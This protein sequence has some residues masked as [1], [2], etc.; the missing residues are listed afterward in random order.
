MVV[1]CTRDSGWHFAPRVS[2]APIHPQKESEHDEALSVP[3]GREGGRASFLLPGFLA[4]ALGD[5]IDAE[6]AIVPFGE[7]LI[8][9]RAEEESANAGDFFHGAD[10]TPRASGGPS[11]KRMIL[12]GLPL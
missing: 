5:W 6:V 11:P 9:V 8:V 7:R 2:Y 3:E 12:D 4:W 10:S 1:S